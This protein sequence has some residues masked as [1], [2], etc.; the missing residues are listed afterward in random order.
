MPGKLWTQEEVTTLVDNYSWNP[1]VYSMLPE[2]SYQSIG[3]KAHTL[4]LRKRGRGD[5]STLEVTYFDRWSPDMAWALGFLVADG[6]LFYQGSDAGVELWRITYTQKEREILEELCTRLGVPHK[7]IA[8]RTGWFDLPGGKRA[9]CTCY[10]VAFTS[11]HMFERLLE[12][13]VMPNKSLQMKRVS[14]HKKYFTHF[15]RGYFDG[16]GCFSWSTKPRCRTPRVSFTSGSRQFLRWLEAKI[17]KYYSM[18]GGRLRRKPKGAWTLRYR[19]NASLKL[20]GLMYFAQDATLFL[21]RK[22]KSLLAYLDYHGM[23]DTARETPEA[24]LERFND[25]VKI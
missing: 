3:F 22:K 16:D 2:R 4:R 8:E 6:N 13:G 1:K 17:S 21:Q 14:V 12:L 11:K 18:P 9:Y 7:H 10:H 5:I 20:M 25:L 15:L 23:V 19:K 24:R